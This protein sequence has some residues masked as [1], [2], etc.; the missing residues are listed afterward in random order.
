MTLEHDSKVYLTALAC[1]LL[2]GLYTLYLIATGQQE[3]TKERSLLAVIALLATV[4]I[5]FIIFLLDPPPIIKGTFFI[6]SH[7]YLGWLFVVALYVLYK[8]TEETLTEAPATVPADPPPVVEPPPP[9]ID[10]IQAKIDELLKKN[11]K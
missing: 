6:Y 7:L 4:I 11:R 2:A 1:G 9:D 10:P 5:T 3:V 8:R